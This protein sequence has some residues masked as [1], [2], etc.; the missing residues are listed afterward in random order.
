MTKEKPAHIPRLKGKLRR[1]PNRRAFPID[2]ILF[3]PGVNAMS[4]MKTK[5]DAML[6]M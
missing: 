1:K 3:G 2:M 5:K 4:V 6:N